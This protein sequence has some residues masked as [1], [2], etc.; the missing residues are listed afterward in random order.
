MTTASA[1]SLYCITGVSIDLG[2]IV[3]IHL[4]LTRCSAEFSSDLLFYFVFLMVCWLVY[5]LFDCLS[6]PMLFLV[7][8]L[9]MT[10]SLISIYGI[11]R[12]LWPHDSLLSYGSCCLFYPASLVFGP[13][14]FLFGLPFGT[15]SFHGSLFGLLFFPFCLLDP[16]VITNPPSA[17]DCCS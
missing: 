4:R 9:F 14:L 7:L 13:F 11:L 17:F 6:F 16:F 5:S 8:S 12:I 10:L 3:E 15:L 2:S 1:D